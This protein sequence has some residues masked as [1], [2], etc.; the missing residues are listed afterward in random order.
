MLLSVDIIHSTFFLDMIASVDGAV[1]PSL[2]LNLKSV[3]KYGYNEKNKLC[4]YSGD[5][6]GVLV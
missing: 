1:V 6:I 4:C 2:L 5:V 3:R